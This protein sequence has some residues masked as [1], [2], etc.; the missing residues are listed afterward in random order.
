MT[1]YIETFLI[2]NIIINF[3]LLRLVEVTIKC[4]SNF[5]NLILGS[6][7]GA[8]FSV[9][10]AIFITNNLIV[11]LIKLIC[12]I[13]MICL[14]FKQTFKQFL[15]NFILLF[16]F[17]YAIGGIIVGLS[18]SSYQTSFGIIISS[19]FNLEIICMF[20]I[21]LTYIIQLVSKNTKFRIKTNNYIYQ[22]TL[23]Q[24]SKKLNI[25]AYLDTGNLLNFNGNPI[26]VVDLDCYLKLTN[27]TLIDYYI[28]KTECLNAGTIS[29]ESSIKLFKIDKVIIN[30]GKNKIILNNQYIGVNANSSFKDTSYKA[31]L[32][33]LLL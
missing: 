16:I 21:I 8:G 2:Q 14:T 12:A 11:N 29:G 25:N 10:C 26:I 1:I 31:L 15:T 4:K 7:I 19:K 3:C 22:T 5:F 23:I 13:F 30:L 28:N 9:V 24:N 6:I 27:T 33:P 18:S 20:V 17:T 32:S